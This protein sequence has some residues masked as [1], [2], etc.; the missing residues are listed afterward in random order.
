[1]DTYE[2]LT[3]LISQLYSF[4]CTHEEKM[5]SAKIRRLT[6]DNEK[7][8]NQQDALTI[9]SWFG[10]AGSFND[11]VISELSGHD[12]GG[13][14]EQAVNDALMD[15]SERIFVLCTDVKRQSV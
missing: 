7:K 2:E 1:M 10:G 15:I 12:L 11:L 6:A 8:I 3:A 13:R 14:D 4:L 9:H 5:W